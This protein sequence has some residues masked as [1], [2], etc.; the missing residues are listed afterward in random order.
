[1]DVSLSLT[2]WYMKTFSSKQ[3][4]TNDGDEVKI[5]ILL[6]SY[7]SRSN[8]NPLIDSCCLLLLL[9]KVMQTMLLSA[10]V[11]LLGWDGQR[12]GIRV[13]GRQWKWQRRRPNDDVRSPSTIAK[14]FS[15]SFLFVPILKHQYTCKH[16]RNSRSVCVIF[17]VCKQYD[18]IP[19]LQMLWVHCQRWHRQFIAVIS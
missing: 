15:E 7:D 3:L 16:D 1:M 13:T 11:H 5:C 19:E 2:W 9:K 8:S 17:H 10:F 12:L 4:H 6:Y 14:Q 18:N